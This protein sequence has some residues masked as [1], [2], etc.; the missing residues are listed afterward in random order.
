MKKTITSFVMLITAITISTNLIAQMS[1]DFTTTAANQDITLPLYGTVSVIVTWGDGTANT[2]YTSSGDKTHTFA[3]AGTYTVLINKNGTGGSLTQFGSGDAYTNADKLVKVNSFGDIGLV[4]LYGAFYGTTNLTEVP[5]TLPSTITNLR[6]TF[7]NTGNTT[8]SNLNSWDVSNVTNMSYTFEGATSFNQDISNWTVSNVTNMQYMFD[9]ATNFNQDLNDWNV[10]SV[11]NMTIMFR[12]ATSFNQAL[13]SWDVGSVENMAAMF[14]RATAFN[15]NI[16]G[17][18]VNSVTDMSL[19]FSEATAFNQNIGSWNVINVTNMYKMFSGATIFNTDISNWKVGSVENM[20]NIF[21]GARAFNQD[22]SNWDISNITNMNNMFSGA[23]AFNQNI[24]SWNVSHVTN[25]KM[26]F[27]VA[28]AFN[29]DINSWDVSNVTDMSSMFFTAETFNQDIGSWE[30][31]NVT[32]MSNMFRSAIAFNQ[33]IGNWDV[34]KVT[35]MAMMFAYA[36]DFNQD[37]GN[38]NVSIV[39]NMTDF[40]KD[41]TLCTANYNSLL[42]GWDALDLRN[43][44]AFNGGKSKYSSGGA[45]A[46]KASIILND[47]WTITDYGQEDEEITWDGSSSS[48]WNTGSNW[49]GDAVPTLTN[50]VVIPD[51]TPYPTIATNGTA[52]CSSLT[53]YSGATL[54][55]QSDNTGTGSLIVDGCTMGD[56]IFK[57]YIDEASKATTWHYVSAPVSGQAINN[58]YMTGNSIYSPNSGTDY[59]FYRWDEDQNYWIIYGSTGN[60]E[61]FGDATFVESRGYAITRSSAGELSFTGTVRTNDVTYAATYTVDKGEGFNV[62]GNPFTS[63]I[64]ITSSATSTENFIA[65]NTALLDDSYEAL[66]IWDEQTGY[67]ENRNDYK[68]ISN[69]A[70]GSY[71]KLSNNYIQPGQAFMVKVVSGGGNLKFNEDMQAH[72]TDNFYKGEKESWPSIELIAEN[73]ELFNSTAIGFNE[74][75]T[76]GLDPSYDIGKLKGNPNIALYTKLA[77]D[78][79]VDFAIQALPFDDLE[80]VEIAVGI[81]VLE[82]TILEF[83]ANL[84][85]LEEHKITLEDR[86]ENIFTNLRKE[87]YFAEISESGTGRFFLHI[88]STTA[89]CE[90]TAETK[91]TCWHTNKKVVVQNPNNETGLATISS[92]S[93]QILCRMELNG[94]ANQELYFNQPTGIYILSFQTSAANFNKKFFVK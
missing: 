23:W 63:S 50:S 49:S 84:E 43:G 91:I 16:S 35:D 67:T 81:D 94:D 88:K 74:N 42:I 33:D 70:I 85:K 9:G 79:G 77:D 90:I 27:Y 45:A 66:Y 24:G 34:S 26:M 61:A 78:N 21:G 47:S 44:I 1:L 17:W 30:V 83:S 71:A 64:G 89:I 2:T 46:A 82:T 3:S 72:S 73:N 29:Q 65:E 39:T 59:S 68:V 19:M 12:D 10:S 51:V 56:V 25:M 4:S 32:D 87:S 69:G 14:L 76:L 7:R 92:V 38:W 11:E 31:G 55:V 5:A 86:Q 60:P 22:I 53:I 15:G 52:S 13:N 41:A 8:I 75:M 54:T 40:L 20:G 18:T 93:G 80:N 57:R 37:I 48:D 62:V 6:A 58:A 36:Y 28:K